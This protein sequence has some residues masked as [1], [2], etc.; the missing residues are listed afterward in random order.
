MSKNLSVEEMARA[1]KREYMKKWRSENGD[2]IKAAQQRFWAKKFT[3]G[4]ADASNS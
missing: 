3:E 4:E 2:K 1:A